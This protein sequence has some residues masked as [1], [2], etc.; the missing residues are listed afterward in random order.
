M[1]ITSGIILNKILLESFTGD[2]FELFLV[3][4]ATLEY[5]F[6]SDIRISQGDYLD[7]VY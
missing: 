6:F 4:K 1:K 3:E 2:L 5:N 7:M